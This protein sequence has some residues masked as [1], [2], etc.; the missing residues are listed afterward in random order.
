VLSIPL[1]IAAELPAIAARIVEK[2]RKLIALCRSSDFSL[3]K[4]RHAVKGAS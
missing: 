4:L 1:A 2:E 3:E